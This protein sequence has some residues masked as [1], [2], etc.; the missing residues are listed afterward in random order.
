MSEKLRRI[1]EGIIKEW[2]LGLPTDIVDGMSDVSIVHIKKREFGNT[3]EGKTQ[4]KEWLNELR[5]IE[6]ARGNG[7]ISM[8]G[9][10][11]WKKS[12]FRVGKKE[13][14]KEKDG[15]KD[16]LDSGIRIDEVIDMP[17]H[18]EEIQEN[19]GNGYGYEHKVL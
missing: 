2:T 9:Y 5:R 16:V 15:L 11:K 19:G 14:T 18:D 3:I 10:E 12:H 6:I 7:I 8:D 13:S 17:K 1:K 4:F